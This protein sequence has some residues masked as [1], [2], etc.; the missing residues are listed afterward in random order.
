MSYH[1]MNMYHGNSLLF[2]QWHFA[3]MAWIS[4]YHGIPSAYHSS[5]TVFCMVPV[6]NNLKIKCHICFLLESITPVCVFCVSPTA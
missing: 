4:K 2:L 3:S 1:F 5:V 6:V